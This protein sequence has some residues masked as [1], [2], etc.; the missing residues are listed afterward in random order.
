MDIQTFIAT[1]VQLHEVMKHT[2]VRQGQQNLQIIPKF[3][4]TNKE[5]N[6]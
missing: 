5:L 4:N 6:S 2:S 3:V 1:M